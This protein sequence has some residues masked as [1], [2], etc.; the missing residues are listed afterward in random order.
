[1]PGKVYDMLFATSSAR[2]TIFQSSAFRLTKGTK[3]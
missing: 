2:Q 1:M 3:F